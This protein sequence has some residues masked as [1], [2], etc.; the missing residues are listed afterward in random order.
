MLTT[1]KYKKSIHD[2]NNYDHDIVK[3]STNIKLGKKVNKGIYKDYKMKTVTLT[4][5]KTCPADCV[6]WEDCYGNNM[7]FAHRI[8]HE[9][10]NLLQKRIYNELLKST[11]QLLLFACTC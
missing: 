10:Q 2:L 7:P 11:N 8:N 5:R 3:N 9:N 4:E 1:T 6:H